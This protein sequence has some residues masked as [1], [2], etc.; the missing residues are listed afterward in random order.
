MTTAVGMLALG[1]LLAAAGGEL[2]VRGTVGLALAFRVPVAVVGVTV[3]AFATSAPELSVAVSAG[4]KGTPAVAI[5]DA[6]GSNVVNIGLILGIALLLGP[7]QAGWKALARDFWFA[8]AAP[9]LTAALVFDGLLSRLDAVVLQ[10]VF[11]VW[12][13][14][15]VREARHARAVTPPVSGATPAGGRLA[16]QLAAGLAL[17][18]GAGIC[19][20]RGALGLGEALS[21]DPF[22]V[23]V[24]LVSV[25]TSVPELATTL[26]ARVRGHEEVALGTVLGSNLFNG[27]FIAPAA[28]LLTPAVVD[29]R[30]VAGSLVAGAVL[31][32]LVAPR[33]GVLTRWRGAP[34]LAAWAGFVAWVLWTRPQLG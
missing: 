32:A 2:F 27:L 5:G 15:T 9:A 6:L 23:G 13:W 22:V 20:V 34:L 24:T 19:V 11:F 3:A 26:I 4:A 31:V 8:L 18:V 1:V 17:L 30:A 16:V 25:G 7:V 28:A 14:L 10:A 33:A 29:W 12:L 21:L